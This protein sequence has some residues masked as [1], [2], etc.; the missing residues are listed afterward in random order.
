[1]HVRPRS[2]LVFIAVAVIA[3]ACSH[4]TAPAP[5]SGH[6]A[7]DLGSVH[8]PVSCSP[9][10]QQQFDRAIALLHH[11]TYPEARHAFEQIAAE[12]PK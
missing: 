12:E 3:V 11:M 10:A 6:A 7:H 5:V 2:F 4:A 1:M 8:F 9:H